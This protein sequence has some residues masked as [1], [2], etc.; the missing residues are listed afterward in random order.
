MAGPLKMLGVAAGAAVTL[1]GAAYAS[2]RVAA[3][4]LRGNH[5]TDRVADLVV[6]FDDLRALPGAD[7]GSIH[8][9]S[10]GDGPP[11]V[12]S[13]GVTLSVRTWVKQMQSLPEAGFRTIAFDHR[14]HGESTVGSQGH[15]LDTLADDFRAVVE[16]L[17]L[18]DAVL[19]GHSMG[20]IAIQ[21][22]CLRHPEIAAERVAGI[23]LLCTMAHT[24]LSANKRL[25]TLVDWLANVTPEA[26]RVLGFDNLG[27]LM[28]RIGFGRNPQPSHVELTR[29]MILACAPET[30]KAAPS[31]LLGLDL[32]AEL[33]RISVPTL[34]IGGT[35]DVITPPAE[36]RRI[37]R[38]VPGARLEMLEGSGHM[39][40][41][42]QAD[43]VDRL[44]AE[45][46]REVQQH[47][48]A[49]S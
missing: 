15:T 4:R 41:L 5:D 16:G 49:V 40:M 25:L 21:L 46:A 8:V 11:I 9:V 48:E 32:T 3:R 24:A 30:R 18:R 43:A 36:S 38:L 12:L 37:A 44:I 6:P 10:R 28:A 19:V 26:G 2:E 13:H 34:V 17:D 33:P 22:F 7:G 27:L 31:V 29:Q 47:A 20:G 14:G 39:A 1:A 45:F 35:N 42:E 23:V